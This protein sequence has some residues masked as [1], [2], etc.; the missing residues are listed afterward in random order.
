MWLVRQGSGSRERQ[1][2]VSSKMATAN[3]TTLGEAPSGTGEAP[4]LPKR[5]E[6][7]FA[8]AMDL[9]C[10]LALGWRKIVLSMWRNRAW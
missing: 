2:G 1:K 3:A 7:F 9:K 4:V 8:I 5:G 10:G 6:G